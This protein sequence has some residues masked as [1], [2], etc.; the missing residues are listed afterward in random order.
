MPSSGVV[1]GQPPEHLEPG[2]VGVRPAV[3]GQDLAFE[4]AKNA[5]TRLSS[6]LG[7]TAP[8]EWRTPAAAHASFECLGGVLGVV[9][10]VE[11]HSRNG[12]VERAEDAASAI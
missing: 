8:I 1:E 3:G 9:I 7:P 10:G 5:S 4:L 2:L 6:A 11:D 12:G